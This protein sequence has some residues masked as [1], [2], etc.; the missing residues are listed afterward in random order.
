VY[1]LLNN[2]L[3]VQSSNVHIYD[4]FGIDGARVDGRAIVLLATKRRLDGLRKRRHVTINESSNAL[5]CAKRRR[6]RIY[7]FSML[8]SAW[9]KTKDESRRADSDAQ[10]VIYHTSLGYSSSSSV[11]TS[12]FPNPKHASRMIVRRHELCKTYVREMTQSR[13]SQRTAQPRHSSPSPPSICH[14]CHESLQL[15]RLNN[16]PWCLWLMLS[17]LY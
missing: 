9:R 16:A 5:V 4:P 13:P 10:S 14:T 11:S 3:R 6:A 1:E 12:H 7:V 2:N 17:A 8:C 15:R